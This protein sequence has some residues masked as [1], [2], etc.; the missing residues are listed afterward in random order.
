MPI[1]I[2]EPWDSR[3]L[4][5]SARNP[6]AELRRILHGTDDEAEALAAA[7][8]SLP[9]VYANLRLLVDS[10]DLE[11]KGGGWW[12]A[13]ARYGLIDAGVR[14]DGTPL[15]GQGDDAQPP[16]QPQ[17]PGPGELL[18]PEFSFDTSGGTTHIT[19]SLETVDSVIDPALAAAGNA[20]PDFKRAVGVTKDGVEGTDVVTPVYHWEET[21]RFAFVTEQYMQTLRR[22]TGTVNKLTWWNRKPREV[23][24]L[25]ATGRVGKDGWA[26]IT[27][28]FAEQ[29]TLFQVPVGQMVVAEKKGWDYLWVAYGPAEDAGTLIEVPR[30]AY[31]ERVYREEDFKDLGIGV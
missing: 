17:R 30:Y 14:A 27:F 11:P 26:D 20:P 21:K 31:V 22:L 4:T 28:K 16:E 23:L 18:G 5:A 29:E 3:R 15:D 24:F 2:I 10:V 8:A 7:E 9:L 19:S 6:S 12:Y 13:T 1:T 25:G